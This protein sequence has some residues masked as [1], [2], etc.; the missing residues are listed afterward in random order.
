MTGENRERTTRFRPRGLP[1]S[2]AMLSAVLAVSYLVLAPF[3]YRLQGGSG[4]SAAAVAA[5]V[6]LV[7]AIG[8][9]LLSQCLGGPNH[10]IAGVLSGMMLRMGLPLAVCMIVYLQSGALAE[11]GFVFYVLAF[12]LVTLAIDTWMATGRAVGAGPTSEDL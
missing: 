6:C 8:G 7:S 9:M 4:L 12:Y 10:A 2:V 5:V 11:A 1:A 3:A